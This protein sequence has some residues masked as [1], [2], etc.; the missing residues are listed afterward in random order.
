MAK[1]PAFESFFPV[2]TIV[3]PEAI[4]EY[5]EQ[6]VQKAAELNRSVLNSVS[7][8]IEGN[9]ELASRLVRCTDPSEAITI[10]KDWLT[11][12]RDAM[13]SEGKGLAAQWLKLCD[14]D[15][16]IAATAAKRATEQAQSNIANLQR[17]AG[18]ND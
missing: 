5:C 1:A 2:N 4:R 16:T 10:Y 12:R 18:G 6:T 17:A 9:F 11:A 13:L 7:Q 8:V 15:L 14:V 3:P